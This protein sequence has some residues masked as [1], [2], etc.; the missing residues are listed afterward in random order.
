MLIIMQG[1]NSRGD[2]CCMLNS[3]GSTR[4]IVLYHE[5]KYINNCGDQHFI[6][7]WGVRKLLMSVFKINCRSVALNK[8]LTSQGA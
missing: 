2:F 8:I 1:D 3:P 6:R 4:R 7:E 5:L